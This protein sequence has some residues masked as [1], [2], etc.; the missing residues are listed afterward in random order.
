MKRDSNGYVFSISIA[1]V[2]SFEKTW[3]KR[4][5]HRF[6]A[7]SNH[8][9]DAQANSVLPRSLCSAKSIT[10]SPSSCA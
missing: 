10:V 5:D 4:R 1:P 8:L 6:S 2:I 3:R 7:G 9:F